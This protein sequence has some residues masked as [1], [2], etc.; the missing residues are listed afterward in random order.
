MTLEDV[1]TLE[2]DHERLRCPACR[3]FVLV[4]LVRAGGQLACRACARGL[5]NGK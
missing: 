4:L 3:Q 1:S 5:P 2:L